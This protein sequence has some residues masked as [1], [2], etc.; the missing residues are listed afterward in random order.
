MSY[1]GT[2]RW[3]RLQLLLCISN[4]DTAV[5]YKAIDMF[6]NKGLVTRDIQQYAHHFYIIKWKHFRR[7]WPFVS[8]IH[9]SPVDSPHKSHTSN[10]ELWCFLWSAHQQMIEQTIETPVIWDAITHIITSELC[11]S[12]VPHSDSANFIFPETSGEGSQEFVTMLGQLLTHPLL[13]PKT[14]SY[15]ARL[16]PIAESIQVSWCTDRTLLWFCA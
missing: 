4:G 6:V 15:K 7:Y 10:A 8:R 13:K 1:K 11:Q 3:L 9:R 14:G 2:H 5:L 16:K 12:S